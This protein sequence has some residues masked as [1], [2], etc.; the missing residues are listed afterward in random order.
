MR[1]FTDKT[2]NGNR[3]DALRVLGAGGALAALSGC[4]GGAAGGGGS[5]SVSSII[6]APHTPTAVQGCVMSAQQVEGPY[7]VDTKLDRSDIR[8]DPK[9]GVIRSGVPLQ[10]SLQ[11]NQISANTCAPLVGA[12]VDIW[13][14]DA[15]GAY[16]GFNDPRAGGDLREQHFLRGFQRTDAQGRVTFQTIYPGWYSGRA[17][18][19]HFKV[20]TQ[21]DGARGH[22]LTSQ[23]YFDETLNDQIHATS[24]YAKH[25]VRD[26]RNERDFIF[27]RGGEA[28]TL[29]VERTGDTLLAQ[30][31]I[32]VQI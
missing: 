30:H 3:R 11:L 4:S 31:V 7:F 5:A 15:M 2:F 21:P 18:H 19:I 9:S 13:Q 32:G 12:M 29:A 6:L 16:S 24:S 27:R 17:V 1:N 8:S 28:L 26:T 14:C 22:A 10:L 25:G 20:R 23:L